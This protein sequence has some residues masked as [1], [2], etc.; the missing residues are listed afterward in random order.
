MKTEE[1]LTQSEKVIRNKPDDILLNEIKY[2]GKVLREKFSKK[3]TVLKALI[4]TNAAKKSS[5][6]TVRTYLK[7]SSKFSLS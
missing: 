1:K 6:N 5:G 4:I 3:A 2:V 7:T